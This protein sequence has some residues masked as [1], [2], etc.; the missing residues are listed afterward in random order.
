MRRNGWVASE[1]SVQS[2]PTGRHSLLTRFQW[3]LL[4]SFLGHMAYGLSRSMA[5]G[6]QDEIIQNCAYWTGDTFA[7]L[8][9]DYL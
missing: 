8:W 9:V 1:G 4:Q 6:T 5:R 7:A 3:M 2:P